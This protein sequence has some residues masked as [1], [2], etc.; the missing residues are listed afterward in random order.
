M[1]SSVG[2]GMQIPSLQASYVGRGHA[3]GRQRPSRIHPHSTHPGARI[4]S[5]PFPVKPTTP[6]VQWDNPPRLLR[7]LMSS[8]ESMNATWDIEL[9]MNTRLTWGRADKDGSFLEYFSPHTDH[10]PPALPVDRL[11][12]RRTARKGA[13]ALEYTMLAHRHKFCFA[14]PTL[15]TQSAVHPNHLVQDA[16]EPYYL[17]TSSFYC[18]NLVKK[19]PSPA[20]CVDP[21][22]LPPALRVGENGTRGVGSASRRTTTKRMT[23]SGA[24]ALRAETGYQS[25]PCIASPTFGLPYLY[26]RKL[27]LTVV[28]P[29]MAYAMPV[30]YKLVSSSEDARKSGT[31]W[32]AKALGKAA[33]SRAPHHQYGGGRPRLSFQPASFILSSR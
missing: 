13:G 28:F 8:S 1:R 10:V 7:V 11:L 24:R 21:P 22:D 20:A 15:W 31:V 32:M 26:V 29:R 2:T 18:F 12:V 5:A 3:H 33:A 14:S 9:V 16:G 6:F 25:R 27:F 30:W 23:G 17:F 4:Q 19:R